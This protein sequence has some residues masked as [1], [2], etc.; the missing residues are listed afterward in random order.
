MQEKPK[1]W[2]EEICKIVYSTLAAQFAK[3]Y[4]GQL[5]IEHLKQGGLDGVIAVLRERR[6]VVLTGP[7]YPHVVFDKPL[8]H[9]REFNH[10]A[11][12]RPKAYC[13]IDRQT[14]STAARQ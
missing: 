14:R 10:G 13:Q 4:H 5:W 9:L 6:L 7:D 8:R 11:K 2:L 1:Y 3:H 12:A